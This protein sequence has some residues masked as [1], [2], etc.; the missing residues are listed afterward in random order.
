M[1]AA[2]GKTISKGSKVSHASLWKPKTGNGGRQVRLY[3]TNAKYKDKS[4][5]ETHY[6]E[7]STRKVTDPQDKIAKYKDYIFHC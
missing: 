2:D 1:V 5:I 7:N 4:D 3:F 6:K